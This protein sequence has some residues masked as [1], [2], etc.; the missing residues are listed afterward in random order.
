MQTL[1]IGAMK[2]GAAKLLSLL[3]DGKKNVGTVAYSSHVSFLYRFYTVSLVF[4]YKI[5]L[6]I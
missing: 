6:R 3:Q 2:D 4:S 5:M 1:V